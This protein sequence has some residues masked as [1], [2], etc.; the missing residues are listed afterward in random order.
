MVFEERE[1]LQYYDLCIEERAQ[2][3]AEGFK[4]QDLKNGPISSIGADGFWLIVSEMRRDPWLRG[5]DGV[6]LEAGNKAAMTILETMQ[7]IN[8][9]IGEQKMLVPEEMKTALFCIHVSPQ[10]NSVSPIVSTSRCFKQDAKHKMDPTIS[11]F[12]ILT[13]QDI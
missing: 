2:C 8:D 13:T 12:S 3:K 7:K 6:G 10:I 4:D 1:K 11:R 5:P 9:N